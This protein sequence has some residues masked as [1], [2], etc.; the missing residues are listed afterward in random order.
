MAGQATEAKMWHPWQSQPFLLTFIECIT[1]ACK[2][3]IMKHVYST[4]VLKEWNK[5]TLEKFFG[6]SESPFFISM[7]ES[8]NKLYLITKVSELHHGKRGIEN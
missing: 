6:I 4:A 2:N 5:G 8:Q 7:G 1:P 3:T